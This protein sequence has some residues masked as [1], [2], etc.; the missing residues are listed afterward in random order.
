MKK[1]TAPPLITVIT[2]VLNDRK[3]ISQTIESVINQSFKNFEYIIVDGGSTDGTLDIIKKYNENI[4]LLISEPDNGIYDAMN[5]GISF[6]NG[7]YIYFLNSGD[8]IINKTCFYDLSTQ[9]KNNHDILYGNINIIDSNNVGNIQEHKSFKR[10]NL[11]KKTICHQAIFFKKEIF[12]QIGVF[13]LDYKI[14]SDYEW[15]LRY[16]FNYGR[17]KVFHIQYTIADYLTGGISFNNEKD[18]IEKYVILKIYFS[19]IEIILYQIFNL[20]S[21]IRNNIKLNQS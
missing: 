19:K 14:K 12:S 1:K 16:Y 17:R 7:R 8:K 13:N 4:D 3:H 5:K 15:L 6:S 9:L 21:F 11:L 2:V 20:K 18:K 10:I